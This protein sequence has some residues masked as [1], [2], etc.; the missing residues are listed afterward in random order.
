MSLP[1]LPKGFG[2]WQVM[3]ATPHEESPQG[4]GYR[5]GPTPHYAV[6]PGQRLKY[7]VDFVYSEVNA[8]ILY[9]MRQED[10]RTDLIWNDTSAVGRCHIYM[11]AYVFIFVL[12]HVYKRVHKHVTVSG[13]TVLLA[14]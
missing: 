2:G 7:D 10:C 3:D 13:K 1:D 8:D 11:Y 5:L 6:K 12:V 4:R 9:Y 14:D